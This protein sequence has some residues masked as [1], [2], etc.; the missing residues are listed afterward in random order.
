MLY[1]ICIWLWDL[2]VLES[3]RLQYHESTSLCPLQPWSQHVHPCSGKYKLSSFPH[4]IFH[5]GVNWNGVWYPL[6][7]WTGT[8]F[9]MK[10]WGTSERNTTPT[11]PSHSAGMRPC[12]C[13][14]WACK[15]PARTCQS[16][17]VGLAK[18]PQWE[19]SALDHPLREPT[20]PYQ[21]WNQTL[22][23]EPAFVITFVN[24]LSSVECMASC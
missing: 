12:C 5:Q 22:C 23:L 14:S 7:L 11:Y 21:P 13:I 1:C 20:T 2:E 6:N 3:K 15:D 10:Y 24:H 16:C 17:N 4:N 9:G 8:S 18:E 19:I